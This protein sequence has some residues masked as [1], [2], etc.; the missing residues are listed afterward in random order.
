MNPFDIICQAL[1]FYTI[2]VCLWCSVGLLGEDDRSCGR[3]CGRSV[4]VSVWDLA[5]IFV[6]QDDTWE[7][8]AHDEGDI[9]GNEQKA[10]IEQR[11]MHRVLYQNEPWI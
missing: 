7:D 5:Y 1:E 11:E 10:R 2:I 8:V 6:I 9:E 3:G 4:L